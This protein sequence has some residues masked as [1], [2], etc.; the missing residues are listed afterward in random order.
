M[1]PARYHA[2]IVQS[3]FRVGKGIVPYLHQTTTMLIQH[4]CVV[5][6]KHE[7]CCEITVVLKV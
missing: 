5:V 6:L 7:V 2:D 3:L 4:E 1:S